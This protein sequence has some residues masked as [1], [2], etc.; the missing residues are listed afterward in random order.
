MRGSTLKNV[1]G[2]RRVSQRLSSSKGLAGGE[3][4]SFGGVEFLACERV[5]RPGDSAAAAGVVAFVGDR[6]APLRVEISS[7]ATDALALAVERVEGCRSGERCTG[8]TGVEVATDEVEAAE[9]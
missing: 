6:R 4:A 3:R 2:G 5:C 7:S 8:A 1:S 9:E